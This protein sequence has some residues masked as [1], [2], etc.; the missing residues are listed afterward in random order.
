MLERSNV[1]STK[2][3]FT[4]STG[5]TG[6]LS[7]GKSIPME[8][9]GS[10]STPRIILNT[11]GGVGYTSRT[12]AY[13]VPCENASQAAEIVYVVYGTDTV[14]ASYVQFWFQ[15]FRS[16]IFDIKD[17]PRTGRPI[18]KNVDKITKIIEVDR[19]VSSHSIA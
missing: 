5:G 12:E 15:L 4:D 16:D 10:L 11:R 3:C 18:L 9:Q 14:T 1:L 6:V 2:N 13:T 19:Y 8:H 7:W 17:A